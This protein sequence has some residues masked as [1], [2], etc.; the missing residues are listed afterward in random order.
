MSISRKRSP[1]LADYT[2]NGKVIKR[3]NAIKD[4]GVTYNDKFSFND[5]NE[6]ASNKAMLMLSFVKR[7]CYGRFNVGTAKMLHS[8][9][10][11]SHIEFATT[12]W[13]PHHAVHIQALDSVQRQFALYANH[14]R[15]IDGSENTYRLR[16]YLDRC[17]ELN[18]K[19]LLR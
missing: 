14:N 2:M 4:L 6:L 12:I 8:A 5:Y 16:P 17:A 18:L 7:H 1:I 10:V 19:S 15:Y 11:R 9:E 3:V 13:A